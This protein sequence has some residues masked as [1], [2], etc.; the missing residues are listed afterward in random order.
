M[1][2]QLIEQVC[3]QNLKVEM[4][5]TDLDQ[6]VVF[7]LLHKKINPTSIHIEIEEIGDPLIE[8]ENLRKLFKASL[9]AHFEKH[10]SS[11]VKEC[12]YTLASRKS[13]DSVLADAYLFLTALLLGIEYPHAF[14]VTQLKNGIIPLSKRNYWNLFKFPFIHLHAE[15]ASVILLIGKLSSQSKLIDQAHNAAR[16]HFNGLDSSFLPYRS[17]F[18]NYQFCNYTDLIARQASFFYLSALATED[19]EIAYVAKIHFSWLSAQSEKNLK[20]LPLDILLLL[21]F[22]DQLFPEQLTPVEPSLPKETLCENLPLVGLRSKD[23]DIIATLSGCN[24]SMGA[25]KFGS[26]EIVAFGPQVGV[27]GDGKLF[28]S[29]AQKHSQESSKVYRDE[30]HFC[31]NGLVG[32][33]QNAP[34]KSYLKMWQHPSSWLQM[35]I[36]YQKN[37]LDIHAKPIGNLDELYFV[38]YIISEQCL[39][40]GQKKFLNQS[41]EQFQGNASNVAFLDQPKIVT[42]E[43]CFEE[44]EMKIIPLEG[45][46]SFWGANYLIAY[47]L[48]NNYR[49]FDWKIT[50]SSR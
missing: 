32:L 30:K 35:K 16:W 44:G 25:L 2:S 24:S 21:K 28:G 17:F 45:E 26:V 14:S 36:H 42:I 22:T 10:V 37:Q 20:G 9:I 41:L 5:K 33:P 7:C 40:K 19:T 8:L 11:S 39:I 1:H 27:L 38:F 6:A 49:A 34:D 12:W 15:L 18:S 31:L 13:A 23:V 46:S 48:K 29:I 4:N 50:G 43:P 3:R 47:S